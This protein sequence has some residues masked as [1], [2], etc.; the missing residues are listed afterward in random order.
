MI[1]VPRRRSDIDRGRNNQISPSLGL[2]VR[3]SFRTGCQD[4]LDQIS[5]DK[6]QLRVLDGV[7][8]AGANKKQ[9]N[10]SQSVG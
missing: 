9:R 10:N 4:E 8:S 6:R 3:I 7:L 5:K 2:G 1:G